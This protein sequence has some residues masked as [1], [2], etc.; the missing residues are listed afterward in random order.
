MSK[1]G[2]SNY[3]MLSAKA[4]KVTVPVLAIA[5]WLATIVPTMAITASYS[6]NDYRACAGQLLRVNINA[7]SASQACAGALRPRDLS[8]CVVSIS[9]RTQ[10]SAV[11][12]LTT[13]RQ[14]RRPEELASCVI[15]IS[16]IPSKEPPNPAILNYCG[17]SLLPVRFGQCVV[18]LRSEIK[19]ALN[20][21][22]DT[23]ISGSDTVSTFTPSALPQVPGSA[24]EF[25][26]TFE[27][28]PIPT[29]P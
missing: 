11:D 20:Q 22:L 18:G 19:F 12:A 14:A 9:R 7:N 29:Q 23:C 5:G 24:T 28:V 10:I 21:A 6:N 2:G 13:C 25:R 16:L 1:K 15:G 26:P 3:K 27:A 17:R 8:S 4:V